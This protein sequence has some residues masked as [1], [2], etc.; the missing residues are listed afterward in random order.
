MATVNKYGK[1]PYKT[2][3]VH[4][5]PGAAGE[6]ECLAKLLPNNV[7]VIEPYQ[8]ALSVN[9]QIEELKLA[10][11]EN[12]CYPVNLVGYSWG[13]WLSY[14][15]AA[16]YPDYVNKL[17]LIS[18]GPFDTKYSEDIMNTRLS[19]LSKVERLEAEQ[20]FEELKQST[21]REKRQGFARF[22]KLMSKAD[23]YSPLI[24]ENFE[25]DLEIRVEIFNNV[26][27]EADKLR[28]N[29]ALLNIGKFIKCPTVAIHGE[30][31]SHPSEGVE[32][33]LQET[34]KD[35]KFIGLKKCGHKPWIEKE[36]KEEFLKILISELK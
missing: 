18:S 17:I 8:T 10:I 13:A 16:R 25:E 27:P 14:L 32:L 22:G 33:C 21:D 36:A 12:G 19:R 15:T 26:W 4:G 35:F 1:A 34:I 11:E 6:L 23:T 7:G 30:Y 29:G 9:G 5:G 28:K 3:L 24:T 2:V 31:D 20:L